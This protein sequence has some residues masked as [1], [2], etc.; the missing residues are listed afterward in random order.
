MHPLPRIF[1]LLLL[2]ACTN[3][4]KDPATDTETDTEPDTEPVVDTDLVEDTE[5]DGDV[6][7][8]TP[9][10]LPAEVADPGGDGVDQ[11]D[12]EAFAWQSFLALNAA[13]V[14]GEPSDTTTLWQGW[15]STADLL[16]QGA[17]PGP[18]GSR[19]YPAACTA[20]YPGTYQD[21]R[22]LD[23][24]DKVDDSFLEASRSGLSNSPV[25]TS[26]GAFLRYEI[27]ISPLT[28]SYVVAAQY[29][30]AATM[31]GASANLLMPCGDPTYTGGDPAEGS[32]LPV[33]QMLDAGTGPIVLKLAWMDTAGL[34]DASSLFTDQL[35][36]Y[37]PADRTTD[38]QETCELQTMA[39]VG[40]H[41]VRKTLGQ[42]AWTWTT[43]EHRNTAPDCT[44]LIPTNNQGTPGDPGPNTGCPTSVAADHWFYP[45]ACSDGTSCA[46]CNDTPTSNGACI[47]PEQPGD[48]G[49][50]PDEPP[51]AEAGTSMLC[52][53]VPVTADGPYAAAWVQNEACASALTG[54]VWSNYE[55]IST[56]WFTGTTT[57]AT[58]CG[59][60]SATVIDQKDEIAPLVTID[61]GDL[62]PF[63]GNTSMESYE[64]SN[65][66]GCHSKATTA[67][68]S[69]P[70]GECGKAGHYCS[71]FG[72]W[73]GIEVP[74]A[75]N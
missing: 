16:A 61:G 8:V 33:E 59:D 32:T 6:T 63:L 44:G 13:T 24:L 56:Q 19:H 40:V 75:A 2:G 23:Q 64:R 4:A 1:T 72:Y 70:N 57:P 46:T 34:A 14:G 67:P 15:S 55:V 69:G 42:Q 65:C 37:T 10:T 60:I 39:L 12:V 71:D 5:P 31:T 45:T 48:P 36:V 43:I 53:Q 47:N 3:S 68:P 30:L 20:A 27:L 73:L 52:R 38:N 7:C 18:S 35:L 21:Y 50:C 62:K 22:V 25:I 66:M 58:A 49:W 28:Y 54:S 9:A 74:A 29:N 51:A 17:T 26:N 41:M 11:A